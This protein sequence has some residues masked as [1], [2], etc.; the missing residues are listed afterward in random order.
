M[1][2][3]ILC[4][5]FNLNAKYETSDLKLSLPT[6]LHECWTKI[7]KKCH[8]PCRLGNDAVGDTR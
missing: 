8:L 1:F 4:V 3:H 6:Y 7:S 2:E 5:N